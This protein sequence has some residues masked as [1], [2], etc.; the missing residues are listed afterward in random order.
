V[1][2]I[3]ADLGTDNAAL[4]GVLG[5]WPLTYIV[6]A[7]PCGV[8]LDRLGVRVGLFGAT[9]VMA[10]SAYLRATADTPFELFIAVAVFGLGG[11]IIS[12]GAPKLIAGLFDG[13]SRGLAMGIYITG[14]SLGTIAALSLTNSVLLP[15]AGDWRS[16]MLIHAGIALTSGVIWLIIAAVSKVP[17]LRTKSEGYSLAAF[18]EMLRNRQVVL[19]LGIG[20][21]VFFINHALNNWLPNL[22]QRS[23]MDPVAAGNW[24][25]IPTLV[26]L[27]ASILLPRFATPQRRYAILTTLFVLSLTAS[28]LLQLQPGPLLVA[29]LAM[30]GIAR[31]T[32][33]TVALLALVELPSIRRNQLGLAGGVFFAAAEIGGMLGP[34]TFGIIADA[35]GG[36]AWALACLTATSLIMLAMTALLSRTS[37]A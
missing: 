19:L 3:R 9:L 15:L 5:A 37:R 20:V 16:V 24:S 4:G 31:G 10:L 25:T 14:P 33:V 1:P 27:A 32:M 11:P 22:L 28:L 17:H 34:L 12:V 18:G 8:L 6:A 7:I 26:G 13:T 30:M 35:T 36:F 21:G 29:G 2:E 23:G